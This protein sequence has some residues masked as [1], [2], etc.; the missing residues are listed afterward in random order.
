MKE[1][2]KEKL[3]KTRKLKKKEKESEGRAVVRKSRQQTPTHSQESG[4]PKNNKRTKA[5]RNL[6]V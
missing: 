4:Q 2:R 3:V 6:G 1:R 5:V